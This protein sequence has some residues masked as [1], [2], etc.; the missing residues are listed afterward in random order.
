MVNSY[1]FIGQFY[2]IFECLNILK[3]YINI[4]STI[5]KQLTIKL[6]IKTLVVCNVSKHSVFLN[7]YFFYGALSLSGNDIPIKGNNNQLKLSNGPFKS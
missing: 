7:L 5:H 6:N 3:T 4:I 1:L 2:N